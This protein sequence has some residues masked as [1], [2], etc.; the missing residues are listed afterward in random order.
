MKIKL[1]LLAFG[2]CILS[3]TSVIAQDKPIEVEISTKI[4][5]V[6]GVDKLYIQLQRLIMLPLMIF[7]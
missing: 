1:I 4:E 2:I 5:L 6:N 7:N 3:L